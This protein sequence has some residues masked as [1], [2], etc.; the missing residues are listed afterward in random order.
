[1]LNEKTFEGKY[2]IATE[3]EKHYDRLEEI[4]HNRKFKAVDN[5]VPKSQIL[6][7]NRAKYK[8]A[9]LK[10]KLIEQQKENLLLYHR[11][12]EIKNR[13]SF[14]TK[15]INNNK[16]L[17]I[18]KFKNRVNKIRNKMKQKKRKKENDITRQHIKK[19]IASDDLRLDELKKH[20]KNHLKRRK[21]FVDLRKRQHMKPEKI[22]KMVDSITNKIVKSPRYS[23]STT[24][25]KSPTI[26]KLETKVLPNETNNNK[27]NN[28]RRRISKANTTRRASHSPNKKVLRRESRRN[29]MKIVSAR[30]TFLSPADI[31]SS[32]QTQIIEH[33]KYLQLKKSQANN[34]HDNNNSPRKSI[35]NKTNQKSIIKSKSTNGIEVYL[36]V[37]TVSNLSHRS[38]SNYQNKNISRSQ[39]LYKGHE[40]QQVS[41]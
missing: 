3:L 33:S 25:L 5:N 27:N 37:N 18:K 21:T 32:N 40:R 24:N 22:K 14:T 28:H 2:K 10:Y 8:N 20:W 35:E 39:Y 16:Q 19:M 30:R 12:N 34:D 7:S 6:K 17:N 15:Y 4:K 23:T 9:S 13:P 26:P 31:L 36:D 38:S 29:T 41:K 1:M 11:L